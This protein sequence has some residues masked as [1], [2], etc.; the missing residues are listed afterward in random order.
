MGG[1][2]G[3]VRLPLAVFAVEPAGETRFV[4]D[5]MLGKLA[6]WLR[7]L[8]YDTLYFRDATD[9]RLL[10][11]ALRER[12]QLLTPAPPAQPLPR[13][14]GDAPAPGARRGAGP[15]A[16]LHAGH[17]ARVLGVRGVQPRLL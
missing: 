3:N 7:A 11:I 14:Q 2:A 1:P 5:V 10:G 16:A 12:R 9:S 13:V 15:G 6:R 8:G 17:S 4:V